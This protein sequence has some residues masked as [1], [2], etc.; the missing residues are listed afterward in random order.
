MVLQ[1][2]PPV[3]MVRPASVLLLQ[4]CVLSRGYW[5]GCGQS[6]QSFLPKSTR[7]YEELWAALSYYLV[8][9]MSRLM[10]SRGQPSLTILWTR[11]QELMTSC[12]Q[13]SHYLVDKMSR[14]NDQLW[15]ALSLSCGQDVKNHEQLWSA[16][17]LSCWQ[18]VK[19]SNSCGQLSHYLVDKMSRTHEQLWSALSYNLVDKM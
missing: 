16:L 8:D 18:Y 19:N 11:C 3:W 9:K 2:D 6:S 15:P 12:G 17:S 14:T 4:C 7:T 13:P 1:G 5:N 10:S